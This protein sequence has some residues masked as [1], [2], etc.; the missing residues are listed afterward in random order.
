M[1]TGRG[2]EGKKRQT[3]TEAGVVLLPNILLQL[4]LSPM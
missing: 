3:L 2:E 4:T 1:M